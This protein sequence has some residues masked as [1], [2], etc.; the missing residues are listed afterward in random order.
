MTSKRMLRTAL[1][2][3]ALC[4]SIGFAAL[5]GGT[6]R[7]DSVTPVSTL[8]Q[9]NR[10]SVFHE[11]SIDAVGMVSDKLAGG[12]G[13]GVVNY[14]LG[15]WTS[16]D[17]TGTGRSFEIN[18]SPVV[19]YDS[20]PEAR[21]NQQAGEFGGGDLNAAYRFDFGPDDAT[22]GHPGEIELYYD[23]VGAF[24]SGPVFK[25]NT[26]QQTLGTSM[27]RSLSD[28]TIVLHLAA[29]DQFTV[30]HDQAFLNTVDV[31]PS[32]EIFP[33]PRSSVELGYDYARLDYAIRT[34][35][36]KNPDANRHT[37]NLKYHF[38]PTPQ[39][40]G[41]P[42]ESPD[43]LGDILRQS[44]R[45]ATVGYDYIFNQSDGS[46]YHYEGNRVYIGL[47]GMQVPGAPDISFDAR[48]AHEWD[49]YK[50]PNQEGPF[51]I[52][53][54]PKARK[55]KDHLDVFTLRGNARL[56]TLP[57]DAGTLS[58]YVQFDIIADRSS[59]LARH[60]NEYV[61][62]GGVSFQY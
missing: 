19:G 1:V 6:A 14:L 7:A 21:R 57:H 13:G 60:F 33:V 18:F 4:G 32:V 26:V 45:R 8:S 48:Y 59:I 62:G 37:I 24:Y 16:G 17:A 61:I 40:A 38:Y 11:Y 22:I 20:N 27:H 34:R 56:Y 42:E 43:Q 36:H 50:S 52:A 39:K 30:E 41:T 3:A 28:N 54:K 12:P 10:L 46:D 31:A 9:A 58:T 15:N 25:A 55:R 49:W 2:R 53:G 29:D 23:V 5:P 47:E 44:L 51:V 35:I